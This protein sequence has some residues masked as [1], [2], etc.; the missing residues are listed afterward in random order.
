MVYS[1]FENRCNNL[2][3]S[4]CS[5]QATKEKYFKT[6]FKGKTLFLALGKFLVPS[7]V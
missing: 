7:A 5:L 1:R 3:L 6:D 2:N 4:P